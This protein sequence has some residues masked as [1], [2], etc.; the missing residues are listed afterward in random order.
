[1]PQSGGGSSTNKTGSGPER[2]KQQVRVTVETNA[3]AVGVKT[4]ASVPKEKSFQWKFSWEGWDG[5]HTGI[6]QK[7]PI[8]DP[9]ME[10]LKVIEGTNAHRVFSLEQVKMS[11]KIGVK[12]AVDGAGFVTGKEFTGFDDGVELRRARI[13]ARGDCLLLMPVSYEL[14]IGYVPDQFYIENSYVAFRK[15]PWIGD[16]KIGQ[17]QAPMGLDFITSS[18]DVSYME[19]AAPLSALAP[20][21][22][23]GFEIGQPVFNQRATWK[24]GLFTGGAGTDV[25]E[26]TKNYGRAITRITV[27]PIYEMDPERPNDARLLHVG[28]SANVLYAGSG[29]VRYRSRPESHLAPYVIDT[30]DITADKALVVGGEAAWV[31]GPFSLQGEYL[32]SWV[33]EK[34]GQLPGFVGLYGSASWFLTGESRPYDRSEGAFGRVIPKQNFNFGRGGWGAWEIAG[35]FSYT[36]LDSEKISGGRLSM[37]MAGVN[38]YL[39]SHVKWRFDYGLGHVSGRQPDGNL[40][41]FQTRMEMD[42]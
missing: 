23:A 36:D 16:L 33:D 17:Y 25:G 7:T 6:A 12:L 14:E 1:M 19:S 26:A 11:G 10:F 30:G 35:R 18:R 29:S 28:F 9:R 3:V 42:F 22:N 38:W 4:N 15:I 39:H 37:L 5:L 27:L 31:N 41:I 32:H 13:Y 20:G 40:S 24:L 8:K 2:L 34:D 21:A